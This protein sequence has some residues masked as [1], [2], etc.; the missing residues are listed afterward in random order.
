[1][2]VSKSLQIACEE[3]PVFEMKTKTGIFF[4]LFSTRGIKTSVKLFS[5]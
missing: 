5:F 2:E 4:V 1:M 3:P